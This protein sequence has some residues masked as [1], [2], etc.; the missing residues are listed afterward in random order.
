MKI[1]IINNLTNSGIFF[2]RGQGIT[3]LYLD[4][5]Y[6]NNIVGN[7]NYDCTGKN[8]PYYCVPEPNK[9]FFFNINS[10]ETQNLYLK[11]GDNIISGVIWYSPEGAK[12]ITSGGPEKQAEAEFTVSNVV[13]YDLTFV[14]AISCGINMT[15]TP[16]SGQPVKV[17]CVPD[18][19]NKLNIDNSLGYPTILSDKYTGTEEAKLMAGCA[20]NLAN[21]VCGQHKCRKFMSN[22]YKDPD[23]YCG[24]LSKNKCQGYCWAMDEWLCTDDR[25]GYGN[26][27]DWPTDCSVFNNNMGSASNTFSCGRQPQKG[28]DGRTYWGNGN[29]GCLEKS[30]DGQP[31]NPEPERNGGTFVIEFI[32]LPWLSSKDNNKDN[33][34][35]NNKDNTKGN[36]AIIIGCL[37]AVLPLV[38]L[39]LYKLL[40]KENKN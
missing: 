32:N 13:S 11:D 9:T 34:K 31:T 5:K 16:N 19:P 38:L 6:T 2:L 39:G 37:I 36:T 1:S 10:G 40:K 7:N 14:E 24:W 35:G 8:K 4:N 22:T 18:K 3:A 27:D 25:C 30:V 33:T 15:Y 29:V 12:K 17:E 23:S 20:D 28:N 26:H 21:T